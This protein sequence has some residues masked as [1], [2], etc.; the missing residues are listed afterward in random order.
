MG[1]AQS[2]FEIVNSSDAKHNT[3]QCVSEDLKCDTLNDKKEKTDANLNDKK[4]NQTDANLNDK[5]KNQTDANLND[6]KDNQTDINLNDKKDNQT[7][8]NLQHKSGYTTDDSS[9]DELRCFLHDEHDISFVK[10]KHHQN[11]YLFKKFSNNS[12][13]P[14]VF[15][16]STTF[17]WDNV[18]YDTCDNNQ[19]KFNIRELHYPNRHTLNGLLD[20]LRS[21]HVVVDVAGFD[22]PSNVITLTN[23]NVSIYFVILVDHTGCIAFSQCDKVSLESQLIENEHENNR[24]GRNSKEWK[25][26]LTYLKNRKRAK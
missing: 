22:E 20:W 21:E 1:Q 8:T 26:K 9:Y 24:T 6:K 4:D 7:T 2:E 11:V 23:E 3:E 16:L 14:V 25:R 10:S 12:A 17:T 19:N 18:H 5:K 15:S 13:R